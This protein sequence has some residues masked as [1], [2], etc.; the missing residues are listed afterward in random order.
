[1][2]TPTTTSTAT[3]AYMT[4]QYMA[5]AK[6]VKSI[7]R[8]N[9]VDSVDEGATATTVNLGYLCTLSM[10]EMLEL[11]AICSLYGVRFFVGTAM[12]PERMTVVIL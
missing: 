11:S 6:W 9:K 4:D 1:M 8:M 10:H 3:N 7:E 2:N 5:A 12:T